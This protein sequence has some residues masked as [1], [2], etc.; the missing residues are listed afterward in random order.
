MATINSEQ[1]AKLRQLVAAKHPA[2][3]WSKDEINAASQAL[4]DWYEGEKATVSALVD[5]ATN[6]GA[7]SHNFTNAIKK[8]LAAH[9]LTQKSAR[10]LT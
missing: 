5:T 7:L 6:A 1:L 10:E 2:V 9:F 4:E 8:T 3:T